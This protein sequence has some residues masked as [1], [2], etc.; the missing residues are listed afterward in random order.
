MLR[1]FFSSLP[2][3][4]FCVAVAFSHSLTQALCGVPGGG[5]AAAA[6]PGAAAAGAFGA[7]AAAG[8]AGA[9][10]FLAGGG[11]WAPAGANSTV[12]PNIRAA[13]SAPAARTWPSVIVSVIDGKMDCLISLL[14]SPC[15]AGLGRPVGPPSSLLA[16]DPRPGGSKVRIA[17]IPWPQPQALRFSLG[18]AGGNVARRPRS[19]PA[20]ASP[21]RVELVLECRCTGAAPG[22]APLTPHLTPDDARQDPPVPAVADRLAA[23]P[24]CGR[25]RARDRHAWHPQARPGLHAFSLRQPRCPKRWSPGAWHARHLR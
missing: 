8:G 4:V 11:A 3:L 12:I 9:L 6:L 2:S 15:T 10:S 17:A 20:R 13:T 19:S 24:E 25:T 7:G 18:L 14:T 21:G 22:A 1:S 16:P 23:E 5:V